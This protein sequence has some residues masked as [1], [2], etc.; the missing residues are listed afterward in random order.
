[1]TDSTNTK[2]NFNLKTTV[3]N[4]QQGHKNNSDQENI[5]S[6]VIVFKIK[7]IHWYIFTL[8]SWYKLL[9]RISKWK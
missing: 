5:F 2:P 1:M 9:L 8:M 7:N 6:N 3:S 4:K